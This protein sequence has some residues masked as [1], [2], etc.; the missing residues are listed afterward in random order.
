LAWVRPHGKGRVAYQAMG[1][2]D[3]VWDSA[4]YQ[5]MLVGLLRWAGGKVEAD[6]TPNL[7]QVAP[8]HATLQPPPPEVKQ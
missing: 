6:L 3:D 1:H 4:A 8:G 2:R 5:S 7:N